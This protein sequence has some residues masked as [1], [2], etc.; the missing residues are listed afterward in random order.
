MSEKD[1][2][3]LEEIAE[4]Y[5]YVNQREQLYEEMGELLVAFSKLRRSTEGESI[6][7]CPYIN[8]V[9][10]NVVEEIADTEVMLEQMKYFLD[11]AGDVE[12]EKHKKI[13]RQLSIVN[14]EK[15][16]MIKKG[17]VLR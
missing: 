11:C 1:R 3:A 4:H 17:R 7:D 9:Y 10:G 2:L 15:I 8:I 14:Q 16:E 6:A 12:V 5:G 13:Q